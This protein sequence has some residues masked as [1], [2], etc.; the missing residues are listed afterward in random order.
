LNTLPSLAHF[1][2]SDGIEPWH[3][4][5]VLDHEGHEFGGV[6]SNVEKFESILLHKFLKRSMCRYSNAMAVGIFEYLAQRDKWLNITSRTD[7]LDDDIELRGRGLARQTTQTRWDVGR[8]KVDGFGL[9]RDLAL[10]RR[11]EKVGES[12]VLGIDVDVDSTI[13]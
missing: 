11:A 13:T 2:A 3:E 9:Y 7:D 8:R 12:P 5:G 6:A 4:A 1:P 10:E